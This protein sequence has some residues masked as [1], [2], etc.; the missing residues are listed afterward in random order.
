MSQEWKK[1][2][3]N[4]GYIWNH[5]IMEPKSKESGLRVVQC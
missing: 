5:G 2:T 3:N 4:W 1:I